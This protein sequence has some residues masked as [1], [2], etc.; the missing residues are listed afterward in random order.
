[1]REE[2]CYSEAFY[3]STQSDSC[4]IDLATDR[5]ILLDQV[6]PP[7][8]WPRIFGNENPVEI[9]VGCGRGRFLLEAAKRCPEINYLGIE[10]APKYIRRTQMRF[11]KHIKH[12][13]SLRGKSKSLPFSNVRLVWSDAAYFVDRYLPE[14][15]VK[16]YHVYFPDPW[17]KKRQHKRRL[18]RS[19]LW[20]QGFTRTL[21]PR[22]GRLYLATDYEEY[23][24]E[25]CARLSQSKTVVEKPL[26]LSE[27]DRIQTNFEMRYLAE[28]RKIYRAMYEKHEV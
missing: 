24:L 19:E 20:L 6:N 3:R 23:F 13:G 7:I 4:I 18:F 15:T 8:C 28:G 2:P 5:K 26:D 16:A 12:T 14:D 9:E 27:I 11:L 25:I 1:M 21:Y 10:R 22:G 17:P